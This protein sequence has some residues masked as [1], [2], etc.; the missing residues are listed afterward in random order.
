MYSKDVMSVC[1]LRARV[2]VWKK[3]DDGDESKEVE[4]PRGSFAYARAKG[5]RPS[6]SFFQIPAASFFFND[7]FFTSVFSLPAAWEGRVT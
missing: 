1:E 3:E 5:V 6:S 4:K 7:F 2:D